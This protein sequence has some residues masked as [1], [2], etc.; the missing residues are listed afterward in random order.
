[1]VRSQNFLKK[2]SPKLSG[3]GL[4]L[5]FVDKRGVRI[6]S[7]EK[8]RIRE[9]AWVE[10]KEVEATKDARSRVAEEGRGSPARP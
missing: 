9:E 2:P 3:P 8:G 1:L 6:S 10:S 5:S 7:R 4:A